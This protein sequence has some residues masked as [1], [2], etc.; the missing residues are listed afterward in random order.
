M[1]RPDTGA[2]QQRTGAPGI[3]PEIQALRAA[4]V[5]LVVVSHLWPSAL[6]GGF[7][8]VDVFFAISGFLITSLLL[9]EIDRTGRL[10]LSEFWAR[11]ARR[12]LPAAL[13]TLL[14]CAIATILFVPLTY[15]Q[16]F[17]NELRASTAY[18][19]NWQLAESAVD[20]FAADDGPSPV[21]HFWSLSA[22][23]QFY[24]VWP[25][26]LLL[27][28]GLT[29]KRSVR[30]RRN[31]II[32][33][34]GALTAVSLGYSLYDTA[35][36]PS[37]AYFI[38]PTRAWEFGAGGLLALLPQI[39]R[40]PGIA[41]AVLSWAGILAILLAAFL[42]TEN[43]PFPGYAALV[44][45][46]GAL[47]VIAAGTP[48]RRWAP[49]PM[50]ELPP[51]QY[52]G[53]VSYSLY[54]W[55]W[56]LL[57]FAPFVVDRSLHPEAGVVI[58]ALALLAAG[59][60]KVLV[61]DP[62]RAGSFLTARG[63][64]WTFAAA[65]AGTGVVLVVAA[66]AMSHMRAEVAA[67]ERASQQILASNP[68][69]FGAAAR[70]P[71]KPVQQPAAALQGRADA[72]RGAQG[73]EPS[74]Q[75]DRAPRRHP[76]LHVRGAE[77]EGE[78]GDRGD[79]RQ[80][81]LALAA[82]A[83]LRG[84]QE[85]LAGVQRHPHELPVLQGRAGHPRADPLRLPALEGRRAQVVLAPSRG[86]ARVR[87]PALRRRGDPDEPARQVRRRGR[88]LPEGVEDAAAHRQAD[89]RDPRHAEDAR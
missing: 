44:P 23:E 57:I 85:G 11:R 48:S 81:R 19:Q 43:T 89:H 45:V 32:G 16:Q 46:L 66:G 72:D 63:G 6:P 22:E 88:R 54:L 38:T 34:I 77:G 74:L 30:V 79:R 15:W 36:D 7:V 75:G 80:P 69:C 20:Y 56:P 67:A 84:A 52:V 12:I 55:H 37:A 64:R 82:V 27:A 60:S 78:D 25:V 21:Q 17:L 40:S 24:V 9:R 87:R 2:P 39:E 29:R 73:A 53:N 59:L 62:V 5:L 28:V 33:V 50:L 86:D 83:R 10:S 49:T 1:T 35:A 70:D 18:V 14:F 47:A 26:L 13:V 58:L 4:A 31:A 51:I 61:E 8:G 68:K 3:R 65:A 41:R 42:F 71:R 76:D